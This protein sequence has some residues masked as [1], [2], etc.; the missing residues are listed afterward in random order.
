MVALVQHTVRITT[1]EEVDIVGGVEEEED[2]MQDSMGVPRK[3]C[4]H[5][6][7]CQEHHLLPELC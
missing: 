1:G 4:S 6:L 5:L 2:T 3:M 7:R